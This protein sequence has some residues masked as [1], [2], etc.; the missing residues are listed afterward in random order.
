M[1]EYFTT[2][3]LVRVNEY[4]KRDWEVFFVTERSS[5][6]YYHMRRNTKWFDDATVTDLDLDSRVQGAYDKFDS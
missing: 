5:G 6:S 4:A 1:Y 2:S 3:S